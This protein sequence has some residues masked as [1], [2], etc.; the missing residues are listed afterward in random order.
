MAKKLSK[1]EELKQTKDYIAFLG[2][3]LASK[4]YKAKVSPEEYAKEKAKLD[5]A[6]FRLKILK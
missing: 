6:R 5:K 3:R 4:N 1:A 2:K